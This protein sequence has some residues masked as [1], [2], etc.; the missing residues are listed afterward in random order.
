MREERAR[1]WRRRRK[2]PLTALRPGQHLADLVAT[3]GGVW[4]GYVAMCRCPAH[5]DKTPSL[6]LRQGNRGILVTCFAGCDPAD[7]LRELGR[8]RLA[9]HSPMPLARHP[10]GQGNVSRLWDEALPVVGSPA[11]RYLHQRNLATDLP[12]L[13]YHPRC[14]LGRSPCTVFR[15]ALIVGVR[16]ARR[17][18]AIQRIFLTPA[19][20][21]YER[22]AMLGRPA[23]GAWQGGAAL[24]ILAVAEGFET[25][26]AFA[27]IHGHPTWS[28]LGARRLHQLHLPGTLRILLIASDNDPEGRRAADH[29]RTTYHR[30]GLEI[31]P[32]PPPQ[33][34]KDWSDVLDDLCKRGGGAGR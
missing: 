17:L 12:D 6:S 23:A 8:V 11:E 18:C 34:F 29:A 3:L 24:E 22:K 19:G 21:G 27:L 20:T 5:S 1:R 14:P 7:I 9:G 4:H 2:T 32:A 28:A 31:R 26:A 25:A 13:R 16:E 30:P 10:G 33:R 15:P